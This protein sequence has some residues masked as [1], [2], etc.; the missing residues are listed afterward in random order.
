MPIFEYKCNSC[1]E[2]FDLLV[3]PSTEVACKSCGSADVQKK[4]S[5]FGVTQHSAAEVPSCAGSCGGGF[6]QGACGS[7]FCGG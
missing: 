1:Q 7:G 4:L 5:L 6:D 2:E 3:N